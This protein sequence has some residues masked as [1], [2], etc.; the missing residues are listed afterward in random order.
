ML[1]IR[2][3]E[4]MLVSL[5]SSV[6][7]RDEEAF[8]VLYENYHPNIYRYILSMVNDEKAAEDILQEVFIT[9]YNKLYKL[10]HFGAIETWLYKIAVN[11]CNTYFRKNKKVFTAD[12]SLLE[13]TVDGHN[14]TDPDNLLLQQEIHKLLDSCIDNLSINLKT[15]IILFYFQDKSIHEISEIMDCPEST[16]KSRLFKAKKH[17]EKNLKAYYKLEVTLSGSGEY[18]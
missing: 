18:Y 2:L 6:T 14:S 10:K 9:V 17:L 1:E 5:I 11:A 3:N 16:V 4:K 13:E 8:K 7:N 12:S 15:A